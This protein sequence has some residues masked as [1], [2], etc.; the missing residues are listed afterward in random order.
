MNDRRKRLYKKAGSGILHRAFLL[1]MIFMMTA[2]VVYQAGR[3][4]TENDGFYQATAV[5]CEQRGSFREGF[6]TLD[7]EKKIE[8]EKSLKAAI[9]ELQYKVDG[10][11]PS[12]DVVRRGLSVLV[13]DSSV[14]GWQQISVS[15]RDANDS[16]FPVEIVNEL[17]ERYVRQCRGSMEAAAE[18]RYETV[19]LK[20]AHAKVAV[21]EARASF[22]K[23]LKHYFEVKSNRAA[24]IGGGD[25]P[26][27]DRSL[28]DSNEPGMV[29]NRRWISLRNRVA[30]LEQYRTDLL[31][32]RTT[33]HPEVNDVELTLEEIKQKLASTPKMIPMKEGSAEGE[34]LAITAGVSPQ[35]V[36]GDKAGP[37]KS[38][39]SLKDP[40][41]D[42]DPASAYAKRKESLDRL[43]EEYRSSALAE[44][45]ERM[46]LGQISGISLSLAVKSEFLGADDRSGRLG[47]LAV[48]VGLAM[49]IGT[50]MLSARL[51]LAP[52]FLTVSQAQASL[53]VPIVGM[54]P[55]TEPSRSNIFEGQRRFNYPLLVAFGMA[56]ISFGIGV[57][58]AMLRGF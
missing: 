17:A 37:S 3:S 23:F 51:N 34:K 28:A 14:P 27:K 5:V 11:L 46:K 26:P 30:Q 35:A 47:I 41:A 2:L 49:S 48:I 42:S 16:N 39:S 45:K 31:V 50:G 12:L 19:K 36:P 7:V 43:E 9:E 4:L 15:Y 57:L 33:L 52:A 38:E 1:I 29:P 21:E 55:A 40:V 20:T 18:N 32:M 56:M 54:I 10:R 8:S 24:R 22:D 25:T 6:R 44:E 58:V 53:S 13:T